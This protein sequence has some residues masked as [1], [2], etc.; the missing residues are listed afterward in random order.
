MKE[1]WIVLGPE[2][3]VEIYR[4]PEAGR[5]QKTLR[6]MEGDE[7]ASA[8]VPGLRIPAGRLFG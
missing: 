2:R 1:Y 4:E 5:Y 8:V 7:L 6:V 3:A